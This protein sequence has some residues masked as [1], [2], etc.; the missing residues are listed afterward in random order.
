LKKG[1]GDDSMRKK[2][3]RTIGEILESAGKE[4][5]KCNIKF[6]NEPNY[7]LMAEA[8]INLYHQTY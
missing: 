4:K 2:E 7:K 3:P 6:I 8:A 1:K 5:S